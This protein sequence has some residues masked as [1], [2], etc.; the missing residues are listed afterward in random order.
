MPIFKR[1]Q[2]RENFRD[3]DAY[4]KFLIEKETKIRDYENLLDDAPGIIRQK[5]YHSIDYSHGYGM[6]NLDCT[7][8][9]EK[10]LMIVYEKAIQIGA[11]KKY[12]KYPMLSILTNDSKNKFNLLLANLDIEDPY[13]DI[14]IYNKYGKKPIVFNLNSDDKVLKYRY[15]DLELK[16]IKICKLGLKK[17]FDALKKELII[18]SRTSSVCQSR[19]YWLLNHGRVQPVNKI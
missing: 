4:Q 8:F 16:K 2:K 15:S 1:Q 17:L 5:K 9:I 6:I 10:G 19:V 12:T 13:K 7:T 3:L 14:E 18:L 11:S